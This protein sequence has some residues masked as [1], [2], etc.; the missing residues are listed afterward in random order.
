MIG[1]FSFISGLIFGI[2]LLISGMANPAKVLA[3]LDI[4]GKWDPS[5]AFVMVGA[6]IVGFFAFYYAKH[7]RKAFCGAEM[8]LPQSRQIDKKLIIGS[9]IFG[10]GWGL[11]G[12]CPGP[13]IVA[14]GAGKLEALYFVI[15]MLIGMLMYD[16][17]ISK[18]S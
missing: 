18:S 4:F 12:F 13:A 5:L 6:I 3:F 9:L 11:V 2:G 16:W 14:L 1:F 7:R 8:K 10:I 15:A 17:W